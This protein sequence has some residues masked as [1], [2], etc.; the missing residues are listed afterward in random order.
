[1]CVGEGVLAACRELDSE[2]LTSQDIEF[3]VAKGNYG[4]PP[5]VAAGPVAL[6]L[7]RSLWPAGTTFRI[8]RRLNELGA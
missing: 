4:R 7:R 5:E 1:M 3:K 8:P 2:M 6:V